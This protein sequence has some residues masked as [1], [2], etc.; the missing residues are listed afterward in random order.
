MNFGS[1]NSSGVH[2][3]I[4]QALVDAS[5]GVAGSYGRDDLTRRACEAVRE[6]LGLSDRGAVRDL[7]GLLLGGDG[8]GALALL[9]RQYDLGVDPQGV[10]RSL[11]ETV[12]GVTL[13]KVGAAPDLAQPAEEAAAYTDWSARLSFPA[14]HRLW[15]LMLKGHEEVARAVLPIE[16]AE[17]ALLRVVHASALPDPGE[18]ARRK[19]TSLE[20][21]GAVR[22]VALDKTGT[23]TRNRPVVIDVATT[24]GATREQVLALAAAL[25]ARS[26]HPLARAILAAVNAVPYA[27]DVGLSASMRQSDSLT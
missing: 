11:L 8:P 27:D 14:L 18:L 4:L 7:L 20:A 1:D 21:L 23:L 9:R 19:A 5:E 24:G 17:M 16:A 3:R 12:H 22:Q 26:E 6:M 10:L 25:E 13:A 2:P 15:Q